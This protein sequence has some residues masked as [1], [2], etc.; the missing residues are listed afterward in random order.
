MRAEMQ[1]D[2]YGHTRVQ[3]ASKRQLFFMFLAYAFGI[4]IC[5]IAGTK[6]GRIGMCTCR[7][8]PPPWR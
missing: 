5:Y 1:A 2:S 6:V 7:E 4:L 8:G 3:L